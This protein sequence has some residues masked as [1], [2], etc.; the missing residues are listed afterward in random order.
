M[1]GERLGIELDRKRRRRRITG[2]Q[3][4]RP[5][6]LLETSDS[7]M[8]RVVADHAKVPGPLT[9]RDPVIEAVADGSI[10]RAPD[11]VG[12]E[13]ADLPIVP[14]SAAALGPRAEERGNEHR[15][16]IA[17]DFPPRRS[18]EPPARQV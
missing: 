10:E 9:G 18:P 7:V 3:R 17:V 11:A 8:S 12:N 14:A 2:A 16:R 5:L 13:G 6:R 1:R 4:H 15:P